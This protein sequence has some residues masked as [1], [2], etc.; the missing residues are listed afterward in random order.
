M[1]TRRG[2]P[3]ERTRHACHAF[4][5]V[6][7]LIDLAVA[8][9]GWPDCRGRSPRAPRGLTASRHARRRRAIPGGLCRRGG[10]TDVRQAVTDRIAAMLAQ[11]EPVF[12]E[13]WTR[14]AA[15]GMPRNGVRACRTA[16]SMC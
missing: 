9:G 14:A 2:T 8:P 15:R 7:I 6:V 11:G 13:R 4:I 16:G 12:R 10:R 1:F 5:V 3:A